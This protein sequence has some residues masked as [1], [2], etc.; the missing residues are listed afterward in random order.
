MRINY[1]FDGESFDYEV[2]HE[3]Y[4]NAIYKLLKQETKES[5]IDII[6]SADMC[7][8]DLRDMLEDELKAYFEDVAYK[9]YRDRRYE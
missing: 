2:E 8:L 6:L 1:R 7:V 5:L 9:E 3:D 4:S